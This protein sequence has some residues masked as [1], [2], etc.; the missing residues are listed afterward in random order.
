MVDRAL[1][2][3]RLDAIASTDVEPAADRIFLRG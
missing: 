2:P 3:N 1:L